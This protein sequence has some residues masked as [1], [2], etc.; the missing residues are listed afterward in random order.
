M[1]YP[2]GSE[3]EPR[4][5]DVYGPRQ[6]LWTVDGWTRPFHV[7]D[8]FVG[9]GAIRPIL[10]GTIID[11][12]WIDWAGW[13]VLIYHGEVAGV[14]TWS[15]SCHGAQR[16]FVGR[17]QTVTE[18]TIIMNE[19]STGAALGRHL[20]LEVYRGAVDR[21]SGAHPGRS[22]SPRAFIRSQLSAGSP[23]GSKD[24]PPVPVDVALIRVR[25]AAGKRRG[26]PFALTS[27]ARPGA[28]YLGG[29]IYDRLVPL[30]TDEEAI[31]ALQRR[32]PG[33]K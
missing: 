14:R 21:G 28:E 12:G 1:Q 29:T 20:H 7:G 9:I 33:L 31:L 3:T 25:G 26:G 19:G 2:N 23:A 22:V 32:F 4:V 30:V 17:G 11:A 18:R 10:P 13:Q 15:R 24:E 5:T 16:P 6:P 27:G 8:D